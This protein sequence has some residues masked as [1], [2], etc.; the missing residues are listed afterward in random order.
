MVC[1]GRESCARDYTIRRVTFPFYSVEFV[2]RGRGTLRLGHGRHVLRPGS[3]FAYGPGVPHEIASDPGEPLLKYFVDFAGCGAKALL[4][5]CG[6][7]PG[8]CL[9]VFAPGEL[10]PLLDELITVGLEGSPQSPGL[11]AKLLECV[12]LRIA[13]LR[14]PAGPRLTPASSTYQRCRHHL[15]EHAARLRTL[16]Q[17]AQE[18]HVDVAYLCRLFRRFGQATPYQYLLRLKMNLAA[19]RLRVPG[20]LVKAVATEVGFIDPFHFSRAFK[21]VLGVSPSRFQQ[22]HSQNRA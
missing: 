3:L 14:A 18:C 15:Q 13:G 9:Q 8:R 12:G 6:L 5:D 17:A 20:A 7:A 1:G 11:C 19:D 10:V 22:L 16:E 4:R 21:A 2:L